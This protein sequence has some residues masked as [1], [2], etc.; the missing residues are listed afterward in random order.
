MPTRSTH[1]ALLALTLPLSFTFAA[2]NSKEAR[3]SEVRE[4]KEYE[5][6]GKPVKWN[7]SDEQRFGISAKDFA[8]SGGGQPGTS[9]ASANA[10][11]DY[12]L[13]SGW[14]ALPPAQFREVNLRVAG[15]DNAEC[16][17]TTLGG[18]GGGL[19]PNVNRWCGQ[20]KRDPLTPEQI[21]ALPTVTWMGQPAVLLDIEGEWGGMSG[22]AS[23]KDWRLVGLLQVTGDKL[24]TLKMTGPR[25]LLG[26]ELENFHKLVASFRAKG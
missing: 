2:C 14:L 25:E 26:R 12:E 1:A 19:A 8:G 22:D 18:G 11:F 4:S 24:R 7:A 6:V 10:S 5:P 20:L 3:E 23:A 17:I 21:A 16:Y 9:S 15:A 13:P